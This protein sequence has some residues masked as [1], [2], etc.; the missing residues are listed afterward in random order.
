MATR[1]GKSWARRQTG[2]L[3][4]ATHPLPRSSQ[5]TFRHV[6]RP[7]PLIQLSLCRAT[8]HRRTTTLL[9]HRGQR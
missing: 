7:L 2:V 5:V 9:L 8:P 4:A 1:V 3:P 6:A